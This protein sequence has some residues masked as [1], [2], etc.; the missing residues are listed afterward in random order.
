MQTVEGNGID[1]SRELVRGD[2]V[3]SRR[4]I[5]HAARGLV[6]NSLELNGRRLAPG[7]K[8]SD[9]GLDANLKHRLRAE[10]H[11]SRCGQDGF[12]LPHSFVV[13]KAP[14]GCV[15]PYAAD[16]DDGQPHEKLVEATNRVGKRVWGQSKV[17]E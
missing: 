8:L 1:A 3:P 9:L 2:N 14:G 13:S 10:A 6:K 17:P 11:P 16:A 4:L 5:D 12:E 7:L 15:Q